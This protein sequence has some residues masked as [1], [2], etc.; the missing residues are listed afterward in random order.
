LDELEL[1]R[2]RLAVDYTF[3]ERGRMLKTNEPL[4]VA[5]AD[6]PDLVV[7]F[8]GG[9]RILLAGAGLAD[10]LVDRLNAIPTAHI[11]EDQASTHVAHIERLLASAGQWTRGGGPVYR[12]SDTPSPNEMAVEITEENRDILSKH[13]HWLDDEFGGWGTAFAAV[14]DGVAVSL[15]FSSRLDDRS[16]EAGL[17][18]VPGYR[19]QGLA[20]LVTQS[21]AASVHAS[22][23]IPFYST[24]FDNTASQA[25]A[26]KLGLIQIGEDY[27]WTRTG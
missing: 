6:A 5:R 11:A 2:L 15:C 19:G 25:V 13:F 24:S 10:D 20:A 21:W 9:Q 23:R 8:A 14:R 12:F 4:D 27:S 17:E 16:A 3:D 26:R 22:G 1:M 7:G 18:T